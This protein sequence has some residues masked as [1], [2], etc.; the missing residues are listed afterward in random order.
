M[1]HSTTTPL[2]I[3]RGARCRLTIGPLGTLANPDA[4]R[5]PSGGLFEP[6]VARKGDLATYVGPHPDERLAE[7]L[8]TA[9]RTRLEAERAS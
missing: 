7:V 4:L 9:R 2:R 6:E 8:D 5:Q 3:E 1:P